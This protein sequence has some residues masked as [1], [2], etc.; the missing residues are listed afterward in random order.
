MLAEGLCAFN[1]DNKAI[2]TEDDGSF[3]E[4]LTVVVYAIC[5]AYHQTHGHSPAQLVFGQ[6]I[7]LPVKRKIDW[8]DIKKRKQKR[9]HKSNVRENSNRIDHDF[10]KGDQ[11][12]LS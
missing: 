3:E 9:I 8:E 12:T 4:Y 10:K 11:V 1:L 7:F 2:N 6:D 5:S